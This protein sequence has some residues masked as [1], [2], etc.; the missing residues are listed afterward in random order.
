MISDLFKQRTEW[1]DI[2]IGNDVYLTSTTRKNDITE[3]FLTNLIEI[4]FEKL[5]DEIILDRCKVINR[6]MYC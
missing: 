4:W 6:I 1:Y 2:K 3:V 5:S